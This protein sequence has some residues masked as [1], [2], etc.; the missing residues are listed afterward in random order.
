MLSED[1]LKVVCSS[2][3]TLGT[4][5]IIACVY[6]IL[7]THIEKG[8]SSFNY[9]KNAHRSS[10]I[11]SWKYWTNTRSQM[12][13]WVI[14]TP[15]PMALFPG[16]WVYCVCVWVWVCNSI[17]SNESHYDHQTLWPVTDISLCH[18]ACICCPLLLPETHSVL[19]NLRLLKCTSTMIAQTWCWMTTPVWLKA[20]K[21]LVGGPWVKI[22]FLHTVIPKKGNKLPCSRN[23]IG[24]WP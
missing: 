10:K 6:L 19:I 7:H 15:W 24:R 20:H 16:W 13:Y 8:N 18:R 1:M 23:Q 22:I 11:I 5:Q 9:L 2:Y 12:H 3:S 17:T 14:L 4:A 21:N